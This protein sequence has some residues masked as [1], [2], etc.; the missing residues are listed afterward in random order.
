MINFFQVVKSY[1]SSISSL[2]LLPFFA[3]YFTADGSLLLTP[4]S[5]HLSLLLSD[6]GFIEF[7][8][9]RMNDVSEGSTDFGMV[10]SHP[11]GPVLDGIGQAKAVRTFLETIVPV[12]EGNSN[13]I[14]GQVILKVLEADS[15]GVAVLAE[16]FPHSSLVSVTF[17]CESLLIHAATHLGRFVPYSNFQLAEILRTRVEAADLVS[18]PFFSQPE[19]ACLTE[20]GCLLPVGDAGSFRFVQALISNKGL[21]VN[22]RDWPSPFSTSTP[23]STSR[24]N[25]ALVCGADPTTRTAFTNQC[26]RYLNKR[27]ERYA[28][29][30][31]G[32]IF[33]LSTTG[34]EAP[35]L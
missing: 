31:L 19:F 16:F 6:Q 1:L 30:G 24:S 14:T 20:E 17:H 29:G 5:P 23:S 8:F 27:L 13:D 2:D 25:L 33:T 34:E 7:F 28:A 11:G 22:R 18:A 3:D 21:D 15:I 12:L 4:R 35:R 10:L 26:Q 32:N 9:N